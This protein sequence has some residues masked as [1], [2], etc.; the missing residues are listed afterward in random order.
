MN[1]ENQKNVYDVTLRHLIEVNKN[2]S[3]HSHPL[4]KEK[5]ICEEGKNTFK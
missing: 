3:T 2:I 4:R 5:K 1:I